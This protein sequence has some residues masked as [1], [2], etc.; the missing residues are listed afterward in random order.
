VKQCETCR[1]RFKGPATQCPLDGGRLVDLPDPLVGRTLSGRYT[2]IERIGA[3]G[4]GAVYRARHEVVEREVA[5]KFLSP[6][7]AMDP[8]SRRRFLREARAA[9]RIHHDHVI[10]ITDYGETE[11]GLVF[12]VMEL[13]T[14]APL[15]D[16]IARGPL[17]IGLALQ[18]TEQVA[19]AL[20]RAHELDV[21]HRDIK[22]ENVYL[23]RRP[24]GQ[25][26]TK[27]LDFGLAQMKGELRLTATGTVFGTPEYMAP[28]Q[29]RGAP[30]TSAV[31]LYAL[32]VVLYEMLV[33]DLPFKGGTP[34][35]ILQHMQA[36][37]PKPSAA[38]PE[39]PRAVD[40][41][42]LRLLAKDPRARHRDAHHLLEDLRAARAQLPDDRPSVSPPSLGVAR[43]ALME[44]ASA[45]TVPVS[46]GH[47][48]KRAGAA[49][50]D[51]RATEVHRPDGPS[52]E[53]RASARRARLSTEGR[54]PGF[55]SH[56]IALLEDLAQRA[57]PRGDVP[58]WLQ[59][60][61][62]ALRSDAKAMRAAHEELDLL[63]ARAADVE[64]RTRETRARIGQALDTLV[65]DESRVRRQVVEIEARAAEWKAKLDEVSRPLLLQWCDL[66]A[67]P[68]SRPEMTQEVAEALQ[69]AGSLA[70]AWLELHR[71][72]CACA[73]ELLDKQRELEDLVF[74]VGQ[75]K[76][77]LGSI[78]AEAEVELGPIRQRSRVLD[79]VVAARLESV[80]RRAE[81]VVQH[82]LRYPELRSELLGSGES[83]VNRAG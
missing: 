78:D 58:S 49:T 67:V 64:R 70:S 79:G 15:S 21:V 14:G 45:T 29:A 76:G 23:L 83:A 54:D 56:R 46:V 82:L 35:L 30:L 9:N 73:R 27:V 26:F 18:I 75:L 50:S 52:A 43:A 81:S 1:A 20:A 69:R 10:E 47:L 62:A 66:P 24:D 19:S 41:I 63:A 8:V 28:E 31:D 38:R 11:D 13:L 32:G 65:A 57:H 3:G 12:L 40:D 36:P 42:V 25:V 68:L 60:S 22:P 5:I 61:L 77:R 6:E 34:E 74:Q 33:G 80:V 44:P 51:E 2:I 55:W 16:E 17:P 59:E 7:L 37:P 72:S 48:S 4:M 71:S 53:G 39:I